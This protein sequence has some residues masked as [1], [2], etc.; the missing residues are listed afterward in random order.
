V[1]PFLHVGLDLFGP[2]YV[3]ANDGGTA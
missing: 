1:E 3:L 2:L